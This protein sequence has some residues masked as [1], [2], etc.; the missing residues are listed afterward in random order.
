MGAIAKL[1]DHSLLHP[2]LTD[3]EL[4]QGCELA[5]KF[6]VACV[7]IKPCAVPN[8]LEWLSG[9][10]VALG[11]VVGFPH[12]DNRT[13]TKVYEADL[14]CEDGATEL[15]MVINIGKAR[16]EDW[17]FVEREIQSIYDISQKYNALLKVIFENDFL[18]EDRLK[19]KLCEICAQ[20]GVDFIKT[21]TGYGFVKR[22]DGSYSYQGAADRD[23]KLMRE[24]SPSHIQIKAAGG[25]RSLDDVLRVRSLGATRIGASATEA[26]LAE[27]KRRG[28]D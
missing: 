8:A 20:V 28:L 17:D 16:G 2:M 3:K 19:I 25:V 26:I 24:H 13:E 27:A 21:S 4:E 22:G 23:L 6:G 10:G 18:T 1:I 5:V 14:A 11:T 7:C 12:G 9:S 15:D